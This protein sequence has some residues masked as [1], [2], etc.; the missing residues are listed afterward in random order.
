MWILT[1]VAGEHA[2][3]HDGQFFPLTHPRPADVAT[4]PTKDEAERVRFVL[5]WAN[6]C[7]VIP[8]EVSDG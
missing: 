3:T 6:Q 4:F 2:M 1:D 7:H 5:R 8:K